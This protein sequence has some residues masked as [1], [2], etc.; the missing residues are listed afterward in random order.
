MTGLVS[1]MFSGSGGG[2][3]TDTGSAT[4]GVRQSF[5]TGGVNIGTKSGNTTAIIIAAAVIMAALLLRGRK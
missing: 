1:S 2:G 3:S 4:S 5:T